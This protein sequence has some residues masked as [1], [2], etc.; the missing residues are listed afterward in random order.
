MF[1]WAYF[2][3]HRKSMMVFFDD[4]AKQPMQ[5]QNSSQQKEIRWVTIVVYIVYGSFAGA[6]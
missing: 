5:L 4:W 3:L 2:M 1:I 6:I